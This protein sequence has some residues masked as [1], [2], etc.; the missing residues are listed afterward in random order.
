MS[1]AGTGAAKPQL[2]QSQL[3]MLWRCGIQFENRYI[4]GQIKPPGVAAVVGTAVHAVASR[5]LQHKLDQKT[6]LPVEA[7][8]DFAADAL[9]DAWKVNGV[10]LDDDERAR[11]AKQVKA[12]ATDR[13]VRLSTLHSAALA[14]KLRPAKAGVSWKFV[15]NVKDASHD[16]AGEVDVR[17]IDTTV[18]DLKTATVNRGQ[19]EADRSEQLSFYSLAHKVHFGV[20]PKRVALDTL[21]DYQRGPQ[22]ITTDSQRDMQDIRVSMARFRKSVEIID[23]G[24]FTPASQSDWWCSRRFCG[25]AENCPFYRG[26]ETVAVKGLKGGTRNGH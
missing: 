22:A 20:L 23:K 16:F 8:Q 19:A 7:V 17:E 4:K 10:R 21:V 2:H 6:L 9:T 14:P 24:A 12:Q 25:F 13:A 15:I 5:N 11:G 18:R 1:D 3:A 26:R